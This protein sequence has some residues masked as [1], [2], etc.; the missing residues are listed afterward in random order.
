MNPY[1]AKALRYGGDALELGRTFAQ[2]MVGEIPAGLQG[3][4]TML[5]TGDMDQ[6]AEDVNATREQFEY[7]PKRPG[8][9][10]AVEK[11]GQGVEFAKDL[12]N[13]QKGAPAIAEGWDKFTTTAPGIAAAATGLA[14]VVDPTRGGGKAARAAE[15]AARIAAL[16][17]VRE[18][19]KPGP[20]FR[21]AVDEAVGGL[22]AR[23][24][25]GQYIATLRNKPGIKGEEIAD[26]GLHQVDPT[27]QLTR[28]QFQEM[29]DDRRP[30][31][32]VIRKS[33]ENIREPE[34]DQKLDEM[35]HTA[36]MGAASRPDSYMNLGLDALTKLPHPENAIVAK[37]AA[38]SPDRRWRE[39]VDQNDDGDAFSK[40]L[41]IA[42][43]DIQNH[44]TV[45]DNDMLRR[46]MDGDE[47]AADTINTMADNVI[48]QARTRPDVFRRLWGDELYGLRAEDAAS[49]YHGGRGESVPREVQEQF[50]KQ[51][52]DFPGARELVT[53]KVR[54]ELEAEPG[55]YMWGNR[56]ELPQYPGMRY[57]GNEQPSKKYAEL[58]E[59]QQPL[60]WH[61]DQRQYHEPHW[62]LAG[63]DLTRNNVTQHL[64]VDEV[65][66]PE[67]SPA[68]MLNELQSKYAQNVGASGMTT[69]PLELS[70]ATNVSD[71]WMTKAR[72]WLDDGAD[73]EVLEN[74]F[75]DIDAEAYNTLERMGEEYRD[76]VLDED[77]IEEYI[78]EAEIATQSG[79]GLNPE[80]LDH[81]I[82]THRGLPFS[83]TGERAFGPDPGSQGE[84][85]ALIDSLQRG[86]PLLPKGLQDLKVGASAELDDWLKQHA[87][88][89]PF[90][91]DPRST[92]RAGTKSWRLRG[93]KMALREAAD[94]GYNDLYLPAGR[95]LPR[96]ENWGEGSYDGGYGPKS[97]ASGGFTARDRQDMSTASFLT[98]D[99]GEFDASF[100]KIMENYETRLPKEIEKYLKKHKAVIEDDR[101]LPTTGDKTHA[102]TGKRI[103]FTPELLSEILRGQELY[104][105]LGGAGLLGL[106]AS[107]GEEQP[108]L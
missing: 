66:T 65:Q 12:W 17:T 76:G 27:M 78:S 72:K 81:Q 100:P 38:A 56:S 22:P 70:P 18:T 106:A 6:A 79:L 51:L 7:A 73:P 48:N 103:R 63:E 33:W 40:A 26:L 16:R 13:A 57:Y 101:L 15:E 60:P 11:I 5:Q 80:T 102:A 43:D 96:I 1:L 9:Q 89:A 34:F 31:R 55:D 50:A 30:K 105:I 25:A 61:P 74:E 95:M 69:D 36:F 28:E 8:T 14:G 35:V 41:E 32:H 59:S 21:S 44:G 68:L 90:T 71:A 92:P 94:R 107:Q 91:N 49:V 88:Q 53:E 42:M 97:R 45:G 82:I 47:E 99:D 52:K 62:P 39:F 20:V 108:Q 77:A 46:F 23:A 58:L 98:S 24:T 19:V 29:I 4:S 3:L 64:R 104:Q 87:E 37:N 84:A 93:L 85:Q 54:K 86:E 75:G 2:P 10:R 67:G 83:S